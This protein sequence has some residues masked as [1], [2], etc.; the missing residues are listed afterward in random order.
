[1]TR[2]TLDIP[3][4]LYS[5][6]TSLA[7]APRW[8][9]GSNVRFRLG[10]AQ[11]IGGWESLTSDLLTGVC[12]TV[13]NWTDS[14]A[15]LNVAFGT[16]SALQVWVGGGLYTIT[17]SGLAAGSIDGT[18]G[19]GFG[20]GTYSTGT[21]SSPSASDY[22]PRTWS[23]A[24]WGENLLACPRGGTIYGWTNNTASVAAALTN[25]PANVTYMM[26]APQDQ[27]FAFGCNEEVS[28]TF[29]PLCIRH[30]S[31]RDNTVWTTTT[32]ST[33]REYILPGGGRIVAAQ[34]MGSYLAV[35]TSHGMFLGTYVGAIG[36]IWRF[37]KVGDQCGLMGPNAV[38]VVGQTA[39]WLGS[40]LQFY[41]Y[42][43]GGAPTPIDCPILTDFTDNITSSQADKIV[44]SS[45]AG[46]SE[47]RWDYPDAR[48]GYENSRYLALCINGV[49]VGAWHRGIL[50]RTARVDAGPSP[51]PISCTYGGNV[52]YDERGT[53]ADG[54]AFAWF[55][56]TSDQY[57][58]INSNMLVRGCWPDIADQ[59]G[60]VSITLTSRFKPQGDEIVAGPYVAAASEDKLDMRANGRLFKVKFSGNAAPTSARLGV[61]VFD[62]VKTS[63]R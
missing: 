42:T 23:L 30:S 60:P 13:F 40:D 27:V 50:A 52:Y 10:R 9:D 48:D 24:A 43:L 18:G 45:T 21:Y 55:I 57:F 49:D 5:D 6:D 26:V 25:A 28:G 58:D 34:E 32:S 11:V 12:R 1:M 17:P 38:I 51:S 63:Q 46:F 44:A 47:I 2:I 7:T 37:D 31:V 53:S 20:T 16:H 35:W 61:P 33:A 36:Q 4:G 59:V 41:S 54:S 39:F 22:F 62:V 15:V 14:D 29:N 3:P 56:E 8:R 19:A